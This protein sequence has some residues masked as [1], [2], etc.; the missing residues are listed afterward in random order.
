MTDENS[1]LLGKSLP[2]R[3]RYES[4]NPNHAKRTP[5]R[6]P[7]LYAVPSTPSLR[8]IR[9]ISSLN[10]P[11]VESYFRAREGSDEIDPALFVGAKTAANNPKFHI[12]A[13]LSY[14][15]PVLQWL[16]NYDFRKS[17]LG[18]FL[19]GVSL[20]SF[21]IPLVMSFATSLAHL[22]PLL[23]LYS[24]IIGATVY[25]I[26]GGVPILIVGPLPSSALIYGQV[27]ETIKHTAEFSHYSTLEISAA[28]SFALSGV[29]LGAGVFRFGFLDNVLSRALLKGF[30][31]AMG[32]IMIVNELAIEMGMSQLAKT[33]PHTTTI[34]K[35]VF[36]FKNF[37]LSHAKTVVLTLV[38]L[39]IVLIVRTIKDKLVNKYKKPSAIYIPELLTMVVTA[40]FLSYYYN[41][42]ADGIE[43]I[44][45]IVRPQEDSSLTGSLFIN[46][47]SWSK[48]S[49]YKEVFSTAFLCTILGYF[50]STTATKSLG[51][52]YNYNISSNRELVALGATNLVVSLIGGLPSFG[53]LGR[54][55]IN[56]LSGATTPMAGIFMSFAVAIAIVYVLPLLYYLPECVLALCTTIIGITVLEEIPHD[57]KFFWDIGGYDEIFTFSVIFCASI[58]WSA[59]AGVTLGVLVAV[60][61]LIKHS[62][63]SRIQILG[64]VPN[65]SVFRNAD[66]LIEESFSSYNRLHSSSSSEA[67]EENPVEDVVAQEQHLDKLTNLIAEIEEIEGVIIVKIP[68]PLNFANS[69][70]LKVR[71]NRIEK[72]GT[73]LV[74]PSQPLTRPF[75]SENIKSV[76]IDCKG[77]TTIDSSAT[78]TLYE[79][80]RRYTEEDKISV[81]FSRVPISLSVR[82]NFQALG[83]VS[84]VNR[85][86]SRSSDGLVSPAHSVGTSANLGKG[87]FLSIEEALKAVERIEA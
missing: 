22:S 25:A 20:A 7:P 34:E 78:Q 70:D 67:G 77:M 52:K 56:I 40:T 15:L 66:E 41:W 71:L 64:R 81:C 29:L 35:L 69:G 5:A 12:L 26:F 62:S 68:E 51:A 30:L 43:V 57:I 87:F 73:L 19:A 54:S 3:T 39:T 8:S 32:L 37:R 60:I 24:V 55:K 1:R 76:I 14:Y 18:D 84:A 48:L 10:E 83:I 61:R 4:P 75:N 9:S 38:T 2:N 59:Q 16:P 47:V 36:V 65:T 23:G 72:Y 49:L 80:V 79:I 85:T 31:G 11:V 13:Y 21:Q 53:A 42:A 82:D 28:T 45:D 86:F 27:I 58:F 50:D 6:R 63:R 44:G 74:H 33:Q 46:P 17:A